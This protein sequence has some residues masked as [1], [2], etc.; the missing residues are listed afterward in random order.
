[1]INTGI[2][3]SGIYLPERKVENAELETMLDLESGFVESR[4]GIKERRWSNDQET[5][6]Y[7]AVQAALN[8]VKDA[9]IDCIDKLVIARDLIATRRAYSIGLPVMQE[10]QKTGIDVSDCA[11]I[12]ICNY[13]PGFVHG[14]NIA[15]LMV[16]SEQSKNA[17]VIASTDY[18]DMINTDKDFN[19]Q[20]PESFDPSKQGILQYSL[21]EKGR[22]QPPALNAFLWGCGAGAVVVGKTEEDKIKGFKT[23]GSQRLKFD[24]Y[25][26]GDSVNKKSFGSLDGKAIY[27][28]AQTEIPRFVD[29]F[30]EEL[31]L[32]SNDINYFIPHQPNPRILNDLSERIKIPRDKMLVSCDKLG[33]MIAA[34]VPITYHLARKEGKIKSGDTIFFCSFGDSYLTASGLI[35]QEK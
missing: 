26:I 16:R 14:L 30:F 19:K 27:R 24:S 28:Y 10:L 9:G 33:N 12:D 32:T 15:Q 17:L 11:S 7:M 29:K 4:T 2:I 25:G 31:H 18:T 5:V 13:C 35:F 3:G 6:E 34:S 20:F 1:M 21:K 22:F 23:K 8:A